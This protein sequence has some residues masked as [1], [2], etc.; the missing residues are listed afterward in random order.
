VLELKGSIRVLCRVRPMLEKE[1]ANSGGEDPPIR[2]L[3]E[4]VLRVPTGQQADK[5][6]EF[7]RV[8]SPED[9]QEQVGC[10]VA[11]ALH[12]VV[13]WLVVKAKAM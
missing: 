4:E 1:R 10:Q 8:F 7:D 9:D 3:N 5:D 11:Q 6:F 13:F 12:T 2:V